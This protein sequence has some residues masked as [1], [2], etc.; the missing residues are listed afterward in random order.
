MPRTGGSV[1]A[2]RVEAAHDSGQGATYRRKHATEPESPSPIR[3]QERWNEVKPRRENDLGILD[4]K[5]DCA[6]DCSGV[7]GG[8]A[9]DQYQRRPGHSRREVGAVHQVTVL[10]LPG[11]APDV[12]LRLAEVAPHDPAYLEA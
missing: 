4:R 2:G 9:A 7:L 12:P 10:A 6:A 3:N 5:G 1:N 11:D 8:R